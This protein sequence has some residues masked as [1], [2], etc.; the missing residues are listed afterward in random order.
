MTLGVPVRMRART[1][2]VLILFRAAPPRSGRRRFAGGCVRILAHR[3]PTGQVDV[4]F[5]RAEAVRRDRGSV[6]ASNPA[7]MSGPAVG[8]FLPS[9]PA[10]HQA[11][12][13]GMGTP[14]LCEES[15]RG[16]VF[17]PKGGCTSS[18]PRD[19]RPDPQVVVRVK[20]TGNS[21]PRRVRDRVD[22]PRSPGLPAPNSDRV[23]LLAKTESTGLEPVS[24]PYITDLRSAGGRL[25][26]VVFS[27]RWHGRA[28]RVGGGRLA[29]S[30]S[31]GWRP[32]R[33]HWRQYLGD[34]RESG[35]RRK[36]LKT[37][38]VTY[39]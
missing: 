27:T 4:R 11:G 23:E 17:P 20:G 37:A 5:K 31:T 35:N 3:P 12:R 39:P 18:V 10:M 25:V 14:P 24:P 36:R 2:W 6:A 15:C 29:G 21:P 16:Q 9:L 7:S 8:L 26:G 19:G 28:C 34:D 1:P 30:A 33:R 32:S 13:L 22:P 38:T